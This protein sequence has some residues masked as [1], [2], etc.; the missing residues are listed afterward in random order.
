MCSLPYDPKHHDH[1]HIVA[2]KGEGPT[3][4]TGSV[5]LRLSSISTPK[6]L[7]VLGIFA[8]GVRIM[9]HSGGDGPAEATEA[10]R[11]EFDKVG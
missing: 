8:L 2:I 5:S 3:W 11:D 6:S 10:I 4:S 7:L 9:A 1:S